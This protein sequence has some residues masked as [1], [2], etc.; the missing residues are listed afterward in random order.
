VR[1]VV[2]NEVL[3]K[4]RDSVTPASIALQTGFEGPASISS[5]ASR[6]I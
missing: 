6:L 3:V 2:A 1:H 4:L 5:A